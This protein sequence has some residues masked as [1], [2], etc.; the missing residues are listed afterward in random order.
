MDHYS[1]Q[2][3]VCISDVFMELR[4]ATISFIKS[5]TCLP[6]PPQDTIRLSLDGFSLNLA[7]EHYFEN[8]SRKFK[9]H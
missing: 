2:R 9:F 4:K 3:S 7:S 1:D 8:Q 6:V 5:C